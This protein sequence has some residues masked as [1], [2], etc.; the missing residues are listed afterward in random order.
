M[1]DIDIEWMTDVRCQ[2]AEGR[3]QKAKAEDSKREQRE[4][5][6]PD[7]RKLCLFN[8][9]YVLQLQLKCVYYVRY[10]VVQ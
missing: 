9:K 8:M 4:G 6:I 1:I 2:K 3:R 10:T 7:R 5:K